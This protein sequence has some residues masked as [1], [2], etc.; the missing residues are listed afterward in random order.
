MEE[1]EG[2]S[3]SRDL[4]VACLADSGLRPP[5]QLTCCNRHGNSLQVRSSKGALGEASPRDSDSD[6]PAEGEDAD[7]IRVRVRWNQIGLKVILCNL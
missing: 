4:L 1:A 6:A 5:S 7:D 3:L 2:M